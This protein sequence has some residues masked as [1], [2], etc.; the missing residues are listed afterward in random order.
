MDVDFDIRQANAQALAY[1]RR[2]SLDIYNRLQSI[3]EDVKF[4]HQVHR[5]YPDLPLL[6]NLRCGGWYVDPA[7]ATP[8]AAYF[9][10]TDGHFGNWSFNLRR[11]NLQI[12]HLLARERGAR[13]FVLVDSTRAGKR[14]PDAL[15]K[16][17]PIWCAVV[18][19][20]MVRLYPDLKQCSGG[21]E[22]WD[23]RLYCPPGSVSEQERVQIEAKVD[24]W[25][26]AL[27]HSSYDIPRLP[28]P[29]RPLWITPSTTVFPSLPSGGEQKYTPI[30][31]VSASKQ[32]QEGLER[33]SN[34]FSYVQGSGDDHEL[35]GMG[36]TPS[37][38][39]A[40][41]D[42]LLGS[43]RGEL[44]VLVKDLVTRATQAPTRET[45]KSPPSPVPAVG[46]RL[47]VGAIPDMPTFSPGG[48]STDNIAIPGV[49]GPV[50]VVAI[51]SQVVEPPSPGEEGDEQARS[52]VFR[53]HLAEG[54][55]GQLALLQVV[56]PSCS[57]YIGAALTA[58]HSVCVCC[59]TGSDAS[60]G[61]VLAVLQMFFDDDGR[62]GNSPMAGAGIRASKESIRT[63][64]QRTHRAATLK[65]VNEFLLSEPSFR[66]R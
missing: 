49:D 22:G 4:V 24:A 51:T 27:V 63:R 48:P 59:D 8:E 65:R 58:G 13:G 19:R 25:A 32:V 62:Y 18:N 17:V 23:V 12:L 33:R 37:L 56:L 2:E 53:M 44:P 29:L 36:L 55:K 57:T 30:I 61:V 21:E 31:C 5:E 60:V 66:R 39:W 20:A 28:H 43:D 3:A 7:I 42:E 54:K 16:T 34:G 14:I 1:V 64:L 6:P 40:H 26:G 35:W 45:W 10:S 52:N 11:P 46:G 38:F 15:S 41:K 47:L 50:S 9:K